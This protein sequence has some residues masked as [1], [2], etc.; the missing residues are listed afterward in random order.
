MLVAPEDDENWHSFI[1]L[2]KI[3][4]ISLSP[5]CSYDTISFTCVN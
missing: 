1:V 2:L 4:A 5:V 3:C